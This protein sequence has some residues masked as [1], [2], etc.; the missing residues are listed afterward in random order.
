MNEK[1]CYKELHINMR[2]NFPNVLESKI[3]IM[4][5]EK[6]DEFNHLSFIG[7]DFW[8]ATEFEV[9]HR[10]IYG[11]YMINISRCVENNE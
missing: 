6:N 9:N 7:L 10:D 2:F 3:V 8:S 5:N 1:I 4:F 11:I